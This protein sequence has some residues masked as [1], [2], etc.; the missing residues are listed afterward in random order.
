MKISKHGQ[1]VMSI[2]SISIRKQ[3][4]L[5]KPFIQIREV[6][7]GTHLPPNLVTIFRNK[8]FIEHLLNTSSQP[9]MWIRHLD[10]I[11]T[12]FTCSKEEIIAFINWF[13]YLHLTIKFSS[14]YN[15]SGLPYIK[16]MG[17]EQYM[18]ISCCYSKQSLLARLY[19]CY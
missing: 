14:E 2:I 16:Q 13:N 15:P 11:F 8:C 17:K 6:D 5:C 19:T 10:D 3:H 7:I 9:S 12:D 4:Y 1:N 18:Q